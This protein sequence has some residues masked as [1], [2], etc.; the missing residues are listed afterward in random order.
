MV[1]ETPDAVDAPAGSHTE[2]LSLMLPCRPAPGTR[3]RRIFSIAT[4]PD[5][6]ASEVTT[7]EIALVGELDLATSDTIVPQV[8][9]WCRR[10]HRRVRLDLGGV[11]FLDAAG[12]RALLRARH[13]A[14]A[15]GCELVLAN[16]HGMPLRVLQLLELDAVLL[17]QEASDVH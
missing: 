14:R 11:T 17:E 8:E 12:V 16:V 13:R 2:T 9:R 6:L 5:V 3:S 15:L 1:R 7:A 10:P 4:C